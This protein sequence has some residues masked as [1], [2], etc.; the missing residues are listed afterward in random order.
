MSSIY[1]TVYGI[2][3]LGVP[4]LSSVLNQWLGYSR[5]VDMLMLLSFVN[6]IGFMG[7]SLL[8][9][10]REKELDSKFRLRDDQRRLLQ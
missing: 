7:S 10:R 4:I 1:S 6:F 3:T 2:I 8:D 5:S 9:I